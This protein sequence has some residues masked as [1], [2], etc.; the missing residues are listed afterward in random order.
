MSSI[1]IEYLSD[2]FPED[3]IKK[4]QKNKLTYWDLILFI[5][6]HE[7]QWEWLTFCVTF[8]TKIS[9]EA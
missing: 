8:C 6:S 2:Y 1:A 4:L 5:V 3:T 7:D 9:P